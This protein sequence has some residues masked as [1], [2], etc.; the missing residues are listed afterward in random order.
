[1]HKLH[2]KPYVVLLFVYWAVVFLRFAKKPSLRLRV[3]FTACLCALAVV[4]CGNRFLLWAIP[5][6]W[7]TMLRRHT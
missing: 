2:G 7:L 5:A 4:D 6:I 3:I 1:M